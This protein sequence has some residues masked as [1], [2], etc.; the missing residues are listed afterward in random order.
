MDEKKSLNADNEKT[1]LELEQRLHQQE[2]VIS[3]LEREIKR[4]KDIEE[5]LSWKIIGS[6]QSLLDNKIFSSGSKRRK[7]YES[8]LGKLRLRSDHTG[9]KIRPLKTVLRSFHHS[10]HFKSLKVKV[11]IDIIIPIYNGF[12]FLEPLFSSIFKNTTIPCRLIVVDDCSTDPR[13][14]PFLEGISRRNKTVML[15]HN[16]QNLGFVKSVNK[17]V[18]HVENHFVV[19]NSDT[20]VPP[21]WLQRLM[22]PIYERKDI[23]S[24]TPFTNA[25]TICSFP[26]FLEDNAL[27]EDYSVSDL[28]AF[29]QQVKPGRLVETPTG[30]GFCMGINKGVVDRIGMFDEGL[31]QGGYGEEN[32]WCMR[33]GRIGF[34]HVIVPNLF[35]SHKHGG[36]FG[37]GIKR[38]LMDDH[39]A[40]LGAKYPDYS[41]LVNAF[42]LDDP[43]KELRDFLIILAS[44]S[45]GAEKPILVIDHRLGGGANAY[46]EAFMKRELER[47]AKVFLLVYDHE[48]GGFLLTYCY[49]SYSIS[50]S[51][52]RFA[53]LF[54]LF[55][56]IPFGEVVV[57]ELVSFP[58][59]LKI[60]SDI[61]ALK[62]RYGC[63]VRL[64]I[65]DYLSVCPCYTLLGADGKYCSV[66]ELKM[67][68]S[69]IA[70]NTGIFRYYVKENDIAAWRKKW[71][72][73]L[74]VVDEIVCFSQSSRDILKRAYPAIDDEKI[75]VIPH[76]VDYLGPL[77]IAKEDSRT[78]TI[79]VLGYIDAEA[80]GLGII[81]RMISSIEKDELDIRI[82]VIG[83]ISETCA[84]DHLQV[85]G[86]Y[87]RKDLPDLIQRHRVDIVF[88]PSICPETFSLV[89]EEAI[90]MGL[91]LAVFDLGAQGER[92]NG[93]EK[94]VVI[95]ETD[96]DYAIGRLLEWHRQR[97]NPALITLDSSVTNGAAGG[98]EG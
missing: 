98:N 13:V 69:C 37:T 74:E 59:P 27:F 44:S 41:L 67:C 64:P 12:E 71:A 38:A 19:L 6:V 11:P 36:S 55:S 76:K 95:E 81:K 87:E 96:P 8:L 39:A 16:D 63:K 4:L 24:T 43:L 62:R 22:R 82:V 25:G 57:N 32:D 47:G 60:L 31:F 7:I 78:L 77:R 92:V 23:A 80:K 89:A 2:I 49:K 40:R 10:P 73:F 33:A 90:T 9:M 14:G 29:F 51:I 85:T 20:E 70:Q 28:D 17:A 5:S 46:R 66:P 34:K 35:V 48:R 75:S 88:V 65:H 86:R 3:R 79:G 61:E 91:P 42:I 30:V 56:F 54:D 93:Y 53:D 72:G 15:I 21:G 94:G 1:S 83:V 26:V 50:H 97:K 52:E 58:G 68:V 18:G 45:C 84:S